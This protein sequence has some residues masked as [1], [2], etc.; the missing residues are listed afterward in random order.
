M[1]AMADHGRAAARVAVDTFCDALIE[2]LGERGVLHLRDAATILGVSPR[3]LER[4]L[5]DEG[6][7]FSQVV[8]TFRWYEVAGALVNGASVGRAADLSGYRTASH[9]SVAFRSRFGVTPRE[10]REAV[11]HDR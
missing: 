6:S 1:S 4:R 8:E 9:F 10:F 5:S 3:T 2:L 11:R 7:S